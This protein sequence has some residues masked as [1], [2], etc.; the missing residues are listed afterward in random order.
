L[1]NLTGQLQWQ[2]PA[3]PSNTARFYRAALQHDQ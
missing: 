1:T 3:V 2:D